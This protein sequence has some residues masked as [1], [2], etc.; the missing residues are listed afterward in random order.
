[1]HHR[2]HEP[3]PTMVYPELGFPHRAGRCRPGGKRLS[4]P[5]RWGCR[6]MEGFLFRGWSLTLSGW[7]WLHEPQPISNEP[8]WLSFHTV[9]GGIDPGN[10][11][12][13]PR[14]VVDVRNDFSFGDVIFSS[15]GGAGSTDPSQSA[16]SQ[17]GWG[18]HTV[19]GGMDPGITVF[20]PGVLEL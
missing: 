15:P 16:I 3:Q 10:H 18:F 12:F 4:Y 7:R 17:W 5:I 20:V 8:V 6:C 9:R 11:C 2:L 1:M 19:R 14:C 13:R